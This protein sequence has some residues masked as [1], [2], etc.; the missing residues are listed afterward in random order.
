M[1]TYWSFD[2]VQIV[3][4]S[5]PSSP[6]GK[7]DE[8][9]NLES[10]CSPSQVW[11]SWRLWRTGAVTGHRASLTERPCKVH[12]GSELRAQ[13]GNQP[14]LWACIALVLFVL[15]PSPKTHTRSGQY[16]FKYHLYMPTTSIFIL[17]NL[18]F[19]LSTSNSQLNVAC[20][21][22]SLLN[23][24]IRSNANAQHSRQFPVSISTSLC[25]AILYDQT[26]EQHLLKSR[27]S[28]EGL[29][30]SLQSMCTPAEY[31]CLLPSQILLYS[32]DALSHS[33]NVNCFQFNVKR[34]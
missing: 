16:T 12:A 34:A 31:I 17:T 8:E 25:T 30:W 18:H 22:E 23:L 4:S 10:C 11:E 26:Q 29:N 6:W 15:C 32:L 28:P 3:E 33:H 5:V 2:E 14:S 24:C 19:L 7:E 1:L 27:V 13:Q 21:L 9:K 20:I